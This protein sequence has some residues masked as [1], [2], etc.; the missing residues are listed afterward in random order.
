[1]TD[2][3]DFFWLFL[4]TRVGARFFA[5]FYLSRSRTQIWPISG[6]YCGERRAEGSKVVC[7]R[8]AG[9]GVLG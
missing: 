4:L 3:F 7:R 9:P 5:A 6:D 1:M 2:G 8:H